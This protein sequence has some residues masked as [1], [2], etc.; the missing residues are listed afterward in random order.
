MD[1]TT[2]LWPPTPEGNKRHPHPTLQPPTD[3]ASGSK[4]RFTGNTG[5]GRG[6]AVP[7]ARSLSYKEARQGG[8]GRSVLQC[9]GIAPPHLHLIMTRLLGWPE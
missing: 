2:E 3:Q 8:Q 5:P 6:A 4:G 9:M 7:S 1:Q